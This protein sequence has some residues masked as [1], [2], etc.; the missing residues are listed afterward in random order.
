M[1][2]IYKDKKGKRLIKPSY[3]AFLDIL[4]FSVKN[5]DN[6]ISYYNRY[7]EI[8]SK[9]LQYIDDNHDL[10]GSQN[11][12]SFELKIFT[13]NFVLG[14]PWFEEAGESEIGNIFDI[15]S[16]LQFNF[17][18]AN[19]FIRGAIGFSPLYM[20]EFVVLGPAIVETYQLE[21]EK[22]IYPRIILSQKVNE[23][24]KRHLTFYGD[25]S[26]SPQN[27]DILLDSDGHYFLNYLHTV[28]EYNRG[29]ENEIQNLL[30]SH[31]DVVISNLKINS[32]DLKVFNKYSWV[33]GY[34]N[35]FC[36][37][38]LTEFKSVNVSTLLIDQNLFEK[39]ISRL[40]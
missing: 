34:H 9:E 31:K 13:D 6:D 12:K 22:A 4:G 18:V 29:Y 3:C 15:L 30:N 16:H 27:L 40:I 35:Y 39:K 2:E 7:L 24:I 25:P 37:N 14:Y 10:S 5:L 26:E 33:A 8:L 28:V 17:A 11:F 32:K 19:F 23:V 36:N 1:L 21:K 38:F 20:D